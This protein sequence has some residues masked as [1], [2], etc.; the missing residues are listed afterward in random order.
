M[1]SGSHRKVSHSEKIWQ[2]WFLALKIIPVLAFVLLLKLL[3]HNYG[4]ELITLNALFTSIVA[5]TIFL[6]GFLISGVLSDYKESEKIPSEL[7]A[8]LE[9]LYDDA[10]TL[11]KG[12]NSKTAKQFISH[13]KSF[14][15]SLVEWFYRKEKTRSILGKLS[16]INEFFIEFEKEGVQANYIIKMKNEQS[17]IRKMILRIHTIRDTNFIASAYAIVEILAFSIALGMVLIKIEPFYESLF[18]TVLVTFLV[19]YMILLIK[20]LDN[21]FEYS[22]NGERGTEIPLKPLHDVASKLNDAVQN[23]AK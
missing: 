9:A 23:R 8:S 15:D 6:L 7:S 11:S 20:D 22:E 1:Q 16:K 19:S 10:Y 21:P 17:S 14:V 13:Q 3:A 5:G 4:Y 12:K 18:F 2:K